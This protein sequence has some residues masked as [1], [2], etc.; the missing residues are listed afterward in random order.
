MMT[1]SLPVQNSKA[2]W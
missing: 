2:W 1:S